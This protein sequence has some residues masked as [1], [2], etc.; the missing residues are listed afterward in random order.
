M[1]PSPLGEVRHMYDATADSYSE[2]MD[3]EIDLSVYA[4]MLG[5]L[6]AHLKNIQGILIDTACGSGHM[7]ARYHERHEQARRLVGVDLSPRMVGIASEKLGPW[8]RVVVGDMRDLKEVED[9]VAAAVMNFFALHHLDP[10]GNGEALA[11]WCRVLQPGGRLVVAA[12]EGTGAIDYGDEADIV[13]LRY[14]SQELDRWVQ[15]AGFEVTRCVVEP[16]KDFPMDAIYLEG[17]KV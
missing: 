11:E 17:L 12:W 15:G 1:K 9:G 7:L 5:R 4:D 6:S 8:A 10:K 16:V 2:M 13:A 3:A 14:S